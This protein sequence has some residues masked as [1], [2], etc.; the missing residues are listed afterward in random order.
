MEPLL[1]T[2]KTAVA[3]TLI[4][5]FAGIFFVDRQSAPSKICRVQSGMI[6]F[7]ISAGNYKIEVGGRNF[8]AEIFFVGR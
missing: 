1:I 6:V 7:E 8:F 5:F 4:T 2:L 3:A